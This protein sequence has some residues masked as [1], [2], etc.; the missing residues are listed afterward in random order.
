MPRRAKMGQ[1]HLFGNENRTSE[2]LLNCV[3]MKPLRDYITP[4]GHLPRDYSIPA[5]RPQ[6][7]YRMLISKMIK[8]VR[9]LLQ[10]TSVTLL[11]ATACYLYFLLKMVE[12]SISDLLS[13]V[14][15]KPLNTK[16]QK[17]I[18][19]VL[20]GNSKQYLGKA[21]TKE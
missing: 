4:T 6:N 17:L 12:A 18:K 1:A 8:Y 19:C 13:E 5:K 14:S 7:S 9:F 2:S 15:Y 21:Y 16:G 20:T 3:I 11:G 10:C